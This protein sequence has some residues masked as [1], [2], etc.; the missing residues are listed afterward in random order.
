M[1]NIVK[2][3]NVYIN[4][5]KISASY[6]EMKKYDGCLY[7]LFEITRGNVN[8]SL[9]LILPIIQA[10]FLLANH[11][12]AIYHREI[13]PDNI[14]FLKDGDK[15]SLYLTD[16]GKCFL[17]DESERITLEIMAI[18]PRMFIVPEYEIGE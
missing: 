16:F 9:R 1:P 3:E 12:P 17:K 2:V 7:D 13:K 11:I 15:Y 5:E 14:L 4:K 18:D 6:V 8:L 10:L